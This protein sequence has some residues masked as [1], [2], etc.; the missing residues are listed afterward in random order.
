MGH[1]LQ[2]WHARASNG[3]FRWKLDYS[4]STVARITALRSNRGP[5]A[6][7]ALE[8]YGSLRNQPNGCKLAIAYGPKSKPKLLCMAGT[9]AN[10][11]AHLA[12]LCSLS[13]RDA[14][15]VLLGTEGVMV[16]LHDTSAYWYALVAGCQCDNP[17]V[18]VE[19]FLGRFN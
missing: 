17:A 19:A 7:Y 10:A 15:N 3:Q 16:T 4:N 14:A 11:A 9:P 2:P 6:K 18:H 5:S 13:D 1:S 12:D 8:H